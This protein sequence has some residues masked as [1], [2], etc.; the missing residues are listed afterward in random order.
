MPL[1]TQGN[2]EATLQIKFQNSPEDTIT[3]L[4]D[5]ATQAIK[6]YANRELEET[7]FTNELYDS[8]W[9]RTM[10]QLR[11]YPVTAVALVEENSVALVEGEGFQWYT[12]GAIARI[13]GRL[14]R[15]WVIGRKIIDVTY[16]AGYSPI[17]DDIVLVCTGIVARHF[18]AGVVYASSPAG[19]ASA[20]TSIALEGSDSISYAEPPG[21][22]TVGN[23]Q[24]LTASDT[25]ALSRYQRRMVL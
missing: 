17:P 25:K 9:G 21:M 12:N 24:M 22:G 13:N 19:A 10:L 23:V 7:T 4:I 18:D 2:V 11:Q 5:G 6:T 15:R 20:I 1:C 14:E 3:F 16:T 8:V